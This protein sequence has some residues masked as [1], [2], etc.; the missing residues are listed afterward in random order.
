MCYFFNVLNYVVEQPYYLIQIINHEKNNFY[1]TNVA[2]L[3][4]CQWTE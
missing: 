3:Y 4:N 2:L 1:P